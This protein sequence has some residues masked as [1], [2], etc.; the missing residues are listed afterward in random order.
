MPAKFL[1]EKLKGEDM[2]A[3][4]QGQRGEGESDEC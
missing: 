4:A 2:I 1:H 3:Q